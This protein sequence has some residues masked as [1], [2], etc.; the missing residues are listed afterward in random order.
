MAT[1]SLYGLRWRALAALL[2][3]GCLLTPMEGRGQPT[4]FSQDVYAT[5]EAGFAYL[6]QHQNT[7]DGVF[8]RIDGLAALAFMEMRASADV[9]AG[10]LGF[11]GLELEDQARVMRAVRGCIELRSGFPANAVVDDGPY[12]LYEASACVMGLTRYLISGGPD[13]VGANQG[14]RAALGDAIRYVLDAQTDP[15]L[16]SNPAAWRYLSNAGTPDLSVTQFG[17]AALAAARV[18]A[19]DAVDRPLDLTV[20]R[21]FPLVR[22]ETEL[23]AYQSSL[24]RYPRGSPV[25]TGAALWGYR[26]ARLPVE[27]ARVQALL[28]WFR[29]HWTGWVDNGD[30]KGPLYTTAGLT[31][32]DM[33]GKLTYHLW[34]V[35]KALIATERG[36]EGA[37]TSRAVGGHRDP[38][39]DGYPDA[40]RTWFYDLAWSLM[41][42]QLADGSWG[43]WNDAARFPRAASTV[44]ALLALQRTLG[45]CVDPDL[46][47]DGFCGDD[48]CPDIPNPDQLDSDDDGLGD[49]C[50]PCPFSDAQL[51]GVDDDGDG[52]DSACDRC[53]GVPDP[54]QA[55]GDADGVGDACDVCPAVADPNQ[56]DLDGDGVGD[57]C[58]NC[59]D[60]PNPGQ[61]DRDDDGAG[62][63]CDCRQD[64]VDPCNGFDDDCD[65]AIDE[66]GLA[67]ADCETAQVGVCTAGRTRCVGGGAV[68]VP[69]RM[70]EA[71][72]CD[73][74]DNDCDG[75][76]DEVPPVPCR[77]EAVGDCAEGRQVCIDA[78][79]LC[80]HVNAPQA[81]TCDGR[82]NNCNG[83]VD[84]G[85]PDGGDD[86]SRGFPGVCADWVTVC[87]AGALLCDESPPIQ[88]ETCNGLDDN[89]NGAVDE[90][91]VDAAQPCHTGEQGI[92]GPGRTACV[93]GALG[94][95]GV[96][97]PEAEK[98]N[99]LDDDCDGI[100][101][102]VDALGRP[103]FTDREGVCAQGTTQC[104][105]GANECVPVVE[106]QNERC[107][108][109]DNDCD[110]LSDE[111]E[112]GA[113]EVCVTGWGGAC[114]AGRTVCAAG[115]LRC[116]APETDDPEACDGIDEDCDGYVDEGARSACGGCLEEPAERCDGVDQDCDGLADEEA[117]CDGET[118]CRYGGCKTL[119]DDVANCA[120]GQ[121]C[122]EGLCVAPC[123]GI[124]CAPGQR[125]ETGR[126][127]D[128][129]ADVE[130]SPGQRC[131]SGICVPAACVTRGCPDGFGCVDGECVPHPCRGLSC[132]P[133]VEGWT[134]LCRDGECV[135]S[136]ALRRCPPGELCLDGRCEAN[137]CE[138][139]DCREG[140]RCFDGRCVAECEPCPEGEVCL[141]SQCRSHPCETARCA[142]AERCVLDHLGH[143]QCE[144]DPEYAG[145][146]AP[147]ADAAPRDAGRP[148]RD[149]GEVDEG[150]I[151]LDGGVDGDAPPVAPPAGEPSC[152]T[153]ARGSVGPP[154]LLLLALLGLRRR[155]RRDAP[156]S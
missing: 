17:M 2:A 59:R 28:I 54:D 113:G 44:F 6:R 120:P 11:D 111:L 104:I 15:D 12:P 81:E 134:Q 103:C 126:C 109:L 152:A 35:A 74:L 90:G 48:N 85:N 50:D 39:A 143:A 116:V 10:G 20:E 25:M 4:R 141:A 131:A 31:G 32:R 58:D 56:P 36:P 130:C 112:P 110:G 23:Y 8:G 91:T 89:C 156:P 108:G 7:N 53:P 5:M 154:G 64:G 151:A 41:E 144:P 63:R 26:M 123:D 118:V 37:V 1:A 114:E 121:L 22:R 76:T 78:A 55:D 124:E 43:G 115:R 153:G 96:R 133:T 92:C 86:C 97:A 13:E 75:V 132:P 46:D 128:A 82:D 84:E 52:V 79:L 83:V 80:V 101:D 125:C 87:V 119:C 142:P 72:R 30:E 100:Y 57:A 136:C 40:P 99:D 145:Q 93:N 27:D 94:C 49:L 122:F 148:A 88:N 155:R 47:Q 127:V 66:D 67:D 18:V 9:R 149:A 98:C 3:F 71:E 73:A 16:Q 135:Q 147:I 24:A 45:A 14:V 42:A 138:A 51:A 106:A 38:V 68:C 77:T 65:D 60:D 139:V 29:D 140:Q 21:Y 102:E 33:Q 70:P 137:P 129:C 61:E 62:D 105:R 19:G 95:V 117:P 34:T 107:D 150:A 146:P 69:V